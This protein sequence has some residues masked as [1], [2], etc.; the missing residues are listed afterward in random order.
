MILRY[1]AV[2]LNLLRKFFLAV[3]KWLRERLG[4]EISVEKS[5]V[6]NLRKNSSEFLGIKFKAVKKGNKMI[7]RSHMTEKSIKRVEHDIKKQIYKTQKHTVENEVVKL[8]SIILGV[9]NYYLSLI[10]I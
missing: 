10:H 4:L 8:N 9:H 3:K 5:K 7:A 2:I 6:T 1:F